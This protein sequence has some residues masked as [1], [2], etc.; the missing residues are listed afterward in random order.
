MDIN[1]YLEKHR[2]LESFGSVSMLKI[3]PRI[4]C[5]DGFNISVQVGEYLY[6]R[7]RINDGPYTHVECGYPSEQEDLLMPFIETDREDPTSSVYPFTPVEVVNA[8]IEKHGGM[9]E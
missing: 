5:K 2:K 9:K 7:P 3:R 8:V 1:E 4:E 6:C